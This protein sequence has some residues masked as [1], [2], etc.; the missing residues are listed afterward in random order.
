MGKLQT[1]YVDLL[2]IH[3]PDYITPDGQISGSKAMRQAQWRAMEKLHKAGKA[4]AIG[5]SHYCRR[6]LDDVLE[7]ATVK[8]AIN[9]VEFHVGM[10]SAGVNA[11]DDREYLESKG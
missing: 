3:F 7:I 4:R 6:Q 1:N 5:I 9:Q 11:T 10:G 8:P 2:L